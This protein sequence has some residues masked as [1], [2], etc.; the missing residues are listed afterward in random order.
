LLSINNTAITHDD[1]GNMTSDGNRTFKYN[2]ENWLTSVVNSSGTTIAIYEYYHD[3]KRRKKITGGKTQ[4]YY[5]NGDQL[6]YITDEYNNVRYSFTRNASG[7][8]LTMT[9]Y[10][11][12]S[13]VNYFYVLNGHGEVIGLRD[14]SGSLVVSYTYDAFGY[15]LTS[16]GTATTGDGLL[17]REQNP[18]RYVHIFDFK[19]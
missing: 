7:K 19:I 17:L 10:T 1:N 6:A 9:D 18:F 3:G 4:Y 15:I 13:P 5:Y 8:L 2:A 16:S 11:G 14:S 12:T